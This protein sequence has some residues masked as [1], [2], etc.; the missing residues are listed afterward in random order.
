MQKGS[1]TIK[2]AE[3]Q[4]AGRDLQ[5]SPLDFWFHISQGPSIRKC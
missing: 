3:L 1:K 5:K 4:N 2:Y